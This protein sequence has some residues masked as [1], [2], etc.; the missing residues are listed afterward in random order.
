M[1]A[2]I[3]TSANRRS[4][5]LVMLRFEGHILGASFASGHRIVVGRWFDS[6]LGAFADVMRRS[7]EGSRTLLATTQAA[8]DFIASHYSFDRV[9]VGTV[10][11]RRTDRRIVVETD[12][13]RLELELRPPGVGSALLGLQPKPL[14]TAPG[15]IRAQDVLFRPLLGPLL[16]GGGR[17]RV[18]GRTRAGVREWYAI[19]S[20]RE[21]RAA[22]MADGVDLGPVGASS[23]AGFGFSEF[24][25]GASMVRV[26][27]LFEAKDVP[28]AGGERHTRLG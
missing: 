16:F 26:T 11:V 8:A 3:P 6:P 24:P 18:T 7:P 2:T 15:W 14:R 21:A 25:E 4:S 9:E 22:G 12:T 27:S 19:H 1:P 23:P 10:S 5:I 20:Y 13:L 28:G 17:T